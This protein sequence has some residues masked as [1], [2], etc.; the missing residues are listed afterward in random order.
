MNK[1]LNK[2]MIEKKLNRDIK[3]LLKYANDDSLAFR[4]EFRHL[5]GLDPSFKS[6]S[7]KSI[8]IM[9]RL[10]LRYRIIPL[11]TFGLNI[12]LETL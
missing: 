10:N 1:S 8:L 2:I 11:H 3:D 5:Y 12:D 6:M 9:L 4:N 7:K